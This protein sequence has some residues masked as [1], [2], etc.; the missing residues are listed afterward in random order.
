MYYSLM[1]SVR[2]NSTQNV[3]HDEQNLRL[4]TVANGIVLDHEL[5]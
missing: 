2:S 1:L 5:Q 4:R 3:V